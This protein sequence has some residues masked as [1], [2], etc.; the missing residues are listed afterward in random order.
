M[1]NNGITEYFEE[2]ETIKEYDGYYYSVSK[3]ITIAILYSIY[4]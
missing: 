3:A 2:V 1:E 4:C